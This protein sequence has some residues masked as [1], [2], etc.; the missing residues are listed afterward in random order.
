MIMANHIPYGYR[1]ENGVA[2]IDESQADQVR[3]LFNG[4][5]SGLGLVPAAKAA[6]L[7]LFYSGAKRML[8]NQHY[9]GDD[10]YPALIDIKTFTRA[11]EERMRRAR[12][13]GRIREQS[14]TAPRKAET[15]FILEK[16]THKYDDPFRQAAYIY[17]L[18]KSEVHDG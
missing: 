11:E 3:T 8:Q 16:I 5:L 9:L 7:L 12:T 13:M 14:K 6:G 17:S 4:Y 2:V 18:I 15:A 1:I 10:F